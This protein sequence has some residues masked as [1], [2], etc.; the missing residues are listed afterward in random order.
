[1]EGGRPNHHFTECGTHILNFLCMFYWNTLQR[2]SIHR[3]M[4]VNVDLT[5]RD[6]WICHSNHSTDCLKTG[7]SHNSVKPVWSMINHDTV[8][9]ALIPKGFGGIRGQKIETLEHCFLWIVWSALVQPH[10]SCIRRF[11]N[12]GFIDHILLCV[13]GGQSIPNVTGKNKS[14]SYTSPF[15]LRWV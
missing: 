3:S 6:H 15:I 7:M 14:F 9:I 2:Y 8:R 5:S 1:M 4:A 11:D 12:F 10:K 13:G